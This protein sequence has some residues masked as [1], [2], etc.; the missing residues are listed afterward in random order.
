MSKIIL[1]I[2]SSLS[3]KMDK[4][5]VQYFEGEYDNEGIYVYQAYCDEIAN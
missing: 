4:I 5:N 3:K 1:Y 2:I